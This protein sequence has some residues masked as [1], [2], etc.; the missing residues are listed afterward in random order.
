MGIRSREDREPA[1][2]RTSTS[3]K[4]A[5]DMVRPYGRIGLDIPEHTSLLRGGGCP[6]RQYGHHRDR[7]H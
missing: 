1:W 7:E 6:R 4:I 5:H 3:Q 2:V